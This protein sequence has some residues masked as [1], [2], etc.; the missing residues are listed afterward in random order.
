MDV[1]I[2]RIFNTYGPNMVPEDKRMIV[3]FIIEGINNRPLPIFGDGTQT[4]SLCYVDDM[5]EG[6]VRLMFYPDTNGKIINLGSSEEHTVL[7]YAKKLKTLG[8]RQ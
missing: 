1:R 3:T 5:V 4:R 2:A 7:E 6:L 8:F